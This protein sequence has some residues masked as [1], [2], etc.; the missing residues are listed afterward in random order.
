M[1]LGHN[2]ESR[3]QQTYKNTSSSGLRKRSTQPLIRPKKFLF[4]ECHE[5]TRNVI[6]KIT[7]PNIHPKQDQ[8]S[9]PGSRKCKAA[10][11]PNISEN[12]G[13]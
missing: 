5:T 12:F 6:K 7:Q 8:R 4:L 11:H 10:L 2:S 3:L 1:E 13:P 9:R